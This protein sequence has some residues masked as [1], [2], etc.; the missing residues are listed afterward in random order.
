[1]RPRALLWGVS[2]A[3]FTGGLL[4]SVL[5]PYKVFLLFL[6]LA[7]APTLFRRGRDDDR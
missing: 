4:I 5:T 6:P 2:L 7:F 3:L 1:M